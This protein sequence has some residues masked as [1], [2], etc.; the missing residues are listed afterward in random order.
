MKYLF[1]VLFSFLPQQVFANPACVVCTVAIGGSLSVAR[2]IGVRD[3]VVGV[4]AG[5]LMA[6]AGYWSIVWFNKKNWHFAGRDFFL[7]ILSLSLVAGVYVSELAYSPQ[8]IL[9]LLWL[10]PFLF[11]Y[12]LGAAIYIYSEKFYDFMKRQNKNHAHFP[13]E[14]V[15]LPVGLLAAASVVLTYYPLS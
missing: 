8:V 12:L 7:M 15:V 14:K 11:S 6:L 10:D 13:F 5:A 3:E 2:K 4:W 1:A 9:G